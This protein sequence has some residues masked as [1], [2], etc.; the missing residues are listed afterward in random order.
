MRLIAG[1]III[2]AAAVLWSA[3]ALAISYAYSTGGNRGAG[4]IATGG[5][6]VIALFGAGLVISGCVNRPD[7]DL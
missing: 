3:G 2:L 7:R 1:A 5:G 4:D 6:I